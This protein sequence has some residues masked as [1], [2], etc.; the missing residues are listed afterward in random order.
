MQ[1]PPIWDGRCQ[2]SAY[3]SSG[4]P[5][6]T[7]ERAAPASCHSVADQVI[8]LLPLLITVCATALPPNQ[9]M[10]QDYPLQRLCLFHLRRIP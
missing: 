7:E 4:V 2:Y 8:A 1:C 6:A 9:R 10:E 3:D 5:P